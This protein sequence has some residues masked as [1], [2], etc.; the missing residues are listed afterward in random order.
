MPR[1]GYAFASMKRKIGVGLCTGVCCTLLMAGEARAQN[2]D[3]AVRLSVDGVLFSGEFTKLDGP[4]D[5]SQEATTT[6]AGLYAGSLGLG[7]GYA[8]SKSAVVGIRA[9]HGSHAYDSKDDAVGTS[10]SFVEAGRSAPGMSRA[11]SARTPSCSV[12]RSRGGW[13]VA[14]IANGLPRSPPRRCPQLGRCQRVRAR[15]R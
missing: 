14:T 6:D 12:F 15:W 3:G 4:G 11:T 9:L 8:P 13:A 7:L 5:S 10:P 1:N 2:T